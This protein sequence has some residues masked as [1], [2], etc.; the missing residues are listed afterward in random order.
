MD[1]LNQVLDGLKL[2]QVLNTVLSKIGFGLL[3]RQRLKCW[4]NGGAALDVLDIWCLTDVCSI[5]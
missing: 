1:G 2:N 5:L 3:F 4:K